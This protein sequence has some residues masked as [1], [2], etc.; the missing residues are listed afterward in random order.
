MFSISSRNTE[1]LRTQNF[2]S[3]L[4][5]ALSAAPRFK[6][7]AVFAGKVSLVS[8]ELGGTHKTWSVHLTLWVSD[9]VYDLAKLNVQLRFD[10]VLFNHGWTRISGQ[11]FHLRSSD[12]L[13][14][15]TVQHNSP[16]L[17]LRM[18]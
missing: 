14:L 2:A 8:P 9:A 17:K 18:L 11:S 3:R 6:T 13:L 16:P 10:I 4:S 15:L 5:S 1:T 7:S 12:A